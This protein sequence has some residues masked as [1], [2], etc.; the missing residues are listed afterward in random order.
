MR[1][2]DRAAS[3]LSAPS[4]DGPLVEFLFA[5]VI[6]GHAGSGWSVCDAI[7]AIWDHCQ[8]SQPCSAGLAPA[9]AMRG[10]IAPAGEAWTET[11][12]VLSTRKRSSYGAFL[13]LPRA[14]GLP[15]V[16]SRPR[17]GAPSAG[18][19]PPPVSAVASG[20]PSQNLRD[21][22]DFRMSRREAHSDEKAPPSLPPA[23]LGPMRCRFGLSGFA[24]GVGRPWEAC[25]CSGL[26][27]RAPERPPLPSQPSQALGCAPWRVGSS[28][29]RDELEARGVLVA[30]ER[31]D[32]AL[33][34][35]RR[36]HPQW[37]RRLSPRCPHRALGRPRRKKRL[38]GR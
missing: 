13:G 36:T 31:S 35:S 30:R 5:R 19:Q 18:G 12:W 32:R 38:G 22:A 15:S 20:R 10:L 26:S 4:I 17:P 16:E 3:A 23:E 6:F 9:G 21:N 24:G 2:P 8:R 7:A 27:A 28:L 37:G 1:V 25:S 33:R 34:T 11:R 29:L 14:G